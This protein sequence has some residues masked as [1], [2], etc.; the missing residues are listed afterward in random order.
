MDSA[1][2]DGRYGENGF[3]YGVTPNSFLA[4]QSHRLPPSS[5]ILC[6]AEGEGRNAVHLAT[7]GHAVTGVDSSS[8][9][10]QKA[11]ELASSKDVSIETQVVDLADFDIGLSKWDAIVSIFCHLPPLLRRDVHARAVRGL[12]PG[13]VVILEAYNPKQLKMKTGGPH[14]ASLLVRLDDL[15]SDFSGLDIDIGQEIERDVVEGKYHTGKA[16]VVQVVA[17]KPKN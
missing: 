17:R 13:G 2:W 1:F 3:A 6:L 8:V 9:G 5:K 11:N 14:S 12:K 16:A 10:L 7:L 4:T 15:R